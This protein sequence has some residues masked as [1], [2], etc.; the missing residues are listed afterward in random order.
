MGI[1]NSPA[2]KMTKYSLIIGE[3]I[4]NEKVTPRGTPAF[5]KLM[6]IGIEEQEQKGVIAPK[7]AATKFPTMPPWLIQAF[8]LCSGR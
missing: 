3:V 4:R 7:S 2:I 1:P 8:S 6:N 5:S